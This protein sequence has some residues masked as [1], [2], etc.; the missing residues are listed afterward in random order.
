MPKKE[1]S[2]R[3]AVVVHTADGRRL[4]PECPMCQ[5]TYWGKLVP[6]DVDPES[7][8]EPVIPTRLK[9]GNTIGM[10]FQLWVCMNCGFLWHRTGAVESEERPEG[11]KE[12]GEDK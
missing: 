2:A 11:D 10:A 3:S 12:D 9:N 6:P 1:K 8:V 4:K 7:V 5:R